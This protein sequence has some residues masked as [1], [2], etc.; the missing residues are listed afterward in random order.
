MLKRTL[1]ILSLVLAI[2][3]IAE[4]VQ[5]VHGI[6]MTEAEWV[7]M[8]S[9][10]TVTE[11]TSEGRGNGILRALKAPF[12]AIGRL[13]GHGKKDDNKLQRIS[14]KDIKKFVST[15]TDQVTTVQ[16]TAQTSDAAPPAAGDAANLPTLVP[17]D[18][19]ASAAEYL[20]K[21]RAYLDSGD[22]NAA[23][24]ELSKASS[25]D[26]TLAEARTLLGV[27]YESK[28]LHDLAMKS[29]A[30]AVEAEAN[31]PQL[32]NNLGY[33]LYTNGDY[34]GATRYLKRAV[35][36]APDNARI[37]NNLGLAQCERGKFDEA[38][39]SF[40]H[41][42]GEYKSRLTIATRLQGEGRNK[43]AIK[44][45]EKA[46][47]LKPN[48]PEVLARLVKLYEVSDKTEQADDARRS[49]IAAQTLANTPAPE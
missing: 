25:L 16:R 31:N 10:A 39:K 20:E 29:F 15:P 45:L 46:R 38:F 5:T 42:V 28:G 37:W 44:Q 8:N 35:K 34:E 47:A 24:A 19:K 48:S 21:G 18:L 13:F 26:R 33:A 27:A 12:K 6:M 14:E 2:V 36:L 4:P 3:V 7:A 40:A 49:L 1:I 23:I 22:L 43:E 32:L 41:A 9:E 17:V 30:A 11:H